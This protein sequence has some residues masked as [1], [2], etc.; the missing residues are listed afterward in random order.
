[1]SRYN[2]NGN[3][4]QSDEGEAEPETNLRFLQ[5]K[6]RASILWLLSKA[7]ENSI[8]DDLR[9]PFYR[10]H[11]GEDRLKAYLVQSLANCELYGRALANIY[12]D[13]NYNTLSH[14]QVMH[15]LMRKGIY[16]QDPQDSSLTESVLLQTAPIKM[17]ML[18]FVVIV[19]LSNSL[20]F[21]SSS[22]SL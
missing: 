3:N 7:F 13:P 20:M 18:C 2:N 1:M 17:V 4:Q 22:S 12:Q 19:I 8:P 11:S 14:S 16:I 15:V 21:C 10:D 6:Q 9:D 5:A